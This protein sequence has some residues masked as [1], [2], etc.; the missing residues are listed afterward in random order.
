[1]SSLSVARTAHAGTWSGPVYTVTGRTP[2]DP[3]PEAATWPGGGGTSTGPNGTGIANG[4]DATGTVTATFTYHPN[5]GDTADVPPTIIGVLERAS[6]SW[7]GGDGTLESPGGPRGRGSAPNSQASPSSTPSGGFTLFRPSH[8]PRLLLV[9]SQGGTGSGGGSSSASNGLN[10]AEQAIENGGISQGTRFKTYKLSGNKVVVDSVTPS[11]HT[12]DP[13]GYTSWSY[14]AELSAYSLY[15][16]SNIELSWKKGTGTLSSEY[17]D[18][19]DNGYLPYSEQ[20]A[21]QNTPNDS[22]DDVWKLECL[23]NNDASMDVHKA[24]TKRPGTTFDNQ[25]TVSWYGGAILNAVTTGFIDPNFS[26]DL[27]SNTGVGTSSQLEVIDYWTMNPFAPYR[28][29]LATG[30]LPSGI[31][32]TFKVKVDEQDELHPGISLDNSYKVFWHKSFEGYADAPDDPAFPKTA[33]KFWTSD[34]ASCDVV[35]EGS[36]NSPNGATVHF[37]RT[38]QGTWNRTAGNIMDVLSAILSSPNTNDIADAL[39][40]EGI[41]SEGDTG[42]KTSETGHNSSGMFTKAQK[43]TQDLQGLLDPLGVQVLAPLGVSH[44][45]CHLMKPLFYTRHNIR[46][47]IGDI[48]G[49]NGYSSQDQRV[50]ANFEGEGWTGIY[51]QIER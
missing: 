40:D 36:I 24:A 44:D 20:V 15:I 46:N 42:E 12:D 49:P 37:N 23:R 5:P 39:I 19:D 18:P 4:P 14:S 30:K 48:Y 43:I 25:P 31:T 2:A 28:L 26:W 32:T 29:N 51:Q 3:R 7:G 50:V 41:I 16:S 17:T 1:M 10:D 22:S 8:R 38:F 6:A 34:I 13:N 33:Y 35:A 47:M 27:A 9:Q 45:N 11:A 21:G